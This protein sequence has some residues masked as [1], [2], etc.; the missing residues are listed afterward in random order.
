MQGGVP[1]V[2]CSLCQVLSVWSRRTFLK[3]GCFLAGA[4]R[5]C[6]KGCACKQHQQHKQNQQQQIRSSV[7][8]AILAVQAPPTSRIIATITCSSSVATAHAL[9]GLV[10]LVV[11]TVSWQVHDGWQVGTTRITVT[12]TVIGLAKLSNPNF[13]KGAR[14]SW[15]KSH[16]L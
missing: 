12:I 10:A 3:F 6:W 9:H 15:G 11:V 1:R 2:C 8:P 5:G 4:G 14:G 7:G 13:E 16:R